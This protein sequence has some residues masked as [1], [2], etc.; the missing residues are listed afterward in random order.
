VEAKALI[1]ELGI[2]VPSYRKYVDKDLYRSFGMKRHIFFDKETFGV[3]KLIVNP[4]RSGADESGIDTPGGE[5]EMKAFLKDA[6][7]SDQ[8]SRTSS[9]CTQRKKTTCPA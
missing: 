9:V 8:A 2:D 6:P 5:A 4:S 1:E 3:D 7:L